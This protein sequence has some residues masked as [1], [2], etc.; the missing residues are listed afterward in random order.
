[1]EKGD[2]VENEISNNREKEFS[3]IKT[4]LCLA[5]AGVAIGMAVGI[6]EVF[7]G[8][9]LLQVTEVRE[10]CPFYFIPF[11]PLAGLLIIACYRKVGGNTQ[12][13]MGLVFDVG[14]AKEEKIPWRLIPLAMVSTWI[15]H[16]FGGSAGREGVAVQIGATVSHGIGR[17]IAIKN[18]SKIFLITGMAAGFAG[19]FETPLAAIF[20]GIEVLVAGQ[21]AYQAILPATTAAFTAW[22]VSTLLNLEKFTFGLHVN[23]KFSLGLLLKLCFLGMIF[24]LVGSL[25][26]RILKF[27]K[28]FFAGKFKNPYIRIFVI[29]ILLSVIFLVLYQGRYSGLGT[30]LINASFGKGQVYSYDWVL[31]FLLT[32]LTLSIGF[33][34]GEVTPLFSIGASLGFVLASVLGLPVEFAAALGF[35]GVFAG[36]TNTLFCPILIGAEIFGFENLP[37]FLIV[38]FIAY[39]CN[40]NQ[41]IYSE[42]KT[43]FPKRKRGLEKSEYL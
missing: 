32:V 16:L 2:T 29:G 25:F 12:R 20:F 41:S 1:M 40:Q 15:T 21:L 5:I 34:G 18:T 28:I 31:K 8:K 9:I 38:C 43:S 30:N 27:A 13:G 42:Q 39:I 26:A 24:G 10:K 4:Y 23:F 33:Q 14:H 11:L 37:Y 19:L 22:G 36:A 7:F 35:A 3:K 6:L 17:K